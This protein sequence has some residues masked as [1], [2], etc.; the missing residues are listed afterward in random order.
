M[1]LEPVYVNVTADAGVT[2]IKGVVTLD[3]RIKQMMPM[4]M[5]M[6]MM[7]ILMMILDVRRHH[8][9]HLDGGDGEARP[10]LIITRFLF[11]IKRIAF[12]PCF[13]SLILVS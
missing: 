11:L 1:L 2:L 9:T 4:M 8:P 7:L 13:L 6:T 5:T 10:N 12:Q 3:F